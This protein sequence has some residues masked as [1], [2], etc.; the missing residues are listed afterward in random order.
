MASYK[1]KKFIPQWNGYKGLDIE[2]WEALNR[3]ES[4]DLEEVPKLAKEY[5]E[6]TN[7]SSSKKE[8]E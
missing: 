6:K 8:S 5:L 1:S 4:V 7:K 2:D 3:G